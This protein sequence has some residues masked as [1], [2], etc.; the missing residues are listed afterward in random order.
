ML[1]ALTLGNFILT[2]AIQAS[3]GKRRRLFWSGI[4]SFT[5]I[6][7]LFKYPE[8]MQGIINSLLQ[9]RGELLQRPALTILMPLGLSFIIFQQLGYL[10]DV[11]RETIPPCS[12]FT[13]FALFSSFFP[14]L[15]SGPIERGG[16]LLPQIAAERRIDLDGAA[17]GLGLLIRGFFK[18][19][20]I[21]DN[22]AFFADKIFMLQRPSPFLLL[23]G[24]LV[25]TV[26]IYADFSGYTDIA[27]ASARLL[28]FELFENFRRPYGA[29]SPSEFWRRWHISLS[30]WLRDYLFLPISYLFLRKFRQDRIL[31]LKTESA[32][33]LA[34]IVLT[35][36][37]A[38]FWHGAAW[39]FVAWGFYHGLLLAIYHLT[40][41]RGNWRPRR[42]ARAAA[43]WLTMQF[44]VLLGWAIFRAPS[45]GWLA[46]ALAH[47]LAESAETA[48]AGL[49]IVATLLMYA[50][51]LLLINLLQSRPGKLLPVQTALHVLMVMAIAIF[52]PAGSNEFIYLQF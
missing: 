49:L 40:G 25:Y 47:P 50:F 19:L 13:E 26:Q 11:Y 23:A 12:S 16:H 51:P 3:P 48:L 9:T 36:T 4:V 21:A 27:R 39:T 6:L 38:G 52:S 43:A 1:L 18:K 7:L 29:H 37:I 31:G 35:M 24:S 28:G 34:G 41:H 17:S 22:I 14:L 45:L 42:G 30:N 2:R 32:A 8:F 10:I 5:A 46:G 15:T 44:L 20:V 33:Y